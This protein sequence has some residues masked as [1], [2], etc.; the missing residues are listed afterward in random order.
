VARYDAGAGAYVIDKAVGG[1]EEIQQVPGKGYFAKFNTART[2]YFDGDPLPSPVAFNAPAGWSIISPPRDITLGN[3]NPAIPYAWYY[4]GTGYVL[5][6]NIPAGGLN[7][8]DDNLDA[9]KG[10]FIKRTAAGNVQIGTAQASAAP[11][12]FGEDA[13]LVQLVASAGDLA[14]TMNFCGIGGDAVEI[15]NPPLVDGAVDLAFAGSGEA[16]AVNVRT[17]DLAQKWD[18][19]VTTS[20]PNTAVTVS[21]PDLSTVPAEY[22]VILTDK[23]SGKSCYLRTSAGFTFE[24][25][26]DGASRKMTLEIVQ[27]SGAALVSSMSVQSGPGAAVVTYGLSGPASVTAEVLNIAGRKVR[28][29]VADRVETAGTHTLVWN[30]SSDAG[31]A[32]PRGLYMI[33]IQAR[34]EDGQ[35]VRAVRPL[36]VN[37]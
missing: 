20:L 31:T 8:V 13:K 37:R 32:V 3:I 27:R 30:L 28:Q 17:G 24:T 1:A 14:D 5:K 7:V 22:A 36:S 25:G 34:S 12:S 23:E 11:I 9:W 33:V 35:Q 18:L 26:A 19:V 16:L 2:A 21:A 29:I 6:A 10:Y 15:S 4:D